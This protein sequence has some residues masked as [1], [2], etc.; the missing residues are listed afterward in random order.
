MVESMKTIVLGL[1]GAHFELIDPWIEEGE[2]PNLKKM[3][4]EGC[5][6]DMKVCLPPVTSP[7]WKCYSTGKNPAELGI[8][9]WE[10]I[11]VKNRRVYYP[12]DR[13][14]NHKEIWDY[15]G[16]EGY[17]VGI[18]GT[19]LTYPARDIN[20]LMVSGGPDAENNS[21]AISGEFKK[22]PGFK[23][24]PNT[25]MKA[26]RIKSAEETVKL[27][28]HNFREALD[29]FE[30]EGLDFMQFTSFNINVL[31]HFLWDH[32]KTL[33]GWKVIDKYLGKLMEKDC[34]T[35]IM[36]DHGSNKIE[37]IFNINIWLEKEGYLKTKKNLFQKLGLSSDVLI[38]LTSKLKIYP[39]LR[40]ILPDKILRKL[41][42][43]GGEVKRE[44]KEDIID[45]EKSKAVAS[46]QGPIYLID[47]EYKKEIKNKL[48]GLKDPKGNEVINKV[49][50]K[51]E[52]YSGKYIKE[53]PDLII[54]QAKGVHI[55]G[56]LGQDKVFGLEVPWVSENKKTGMFMAYGPKIKSKGRIEG[57][58]ILDLA[59]TILRLHGTRKPKG[60]DGKVIEKIKKQGR[61]VKNE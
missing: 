3:K 20:G 17:K 14:F 43:K 41:P 12:Q 16:E 50:E 10:N 60:M 58:S 21:K 59:P 22:R 55:P 34:Q 49:Y 31:H 26:D 45:W 7:N 36:S 37:T 32:E 25:P 48:E 42:S 2:L 29:L 15:L 19:P 23:V 38:K 24:R 61:V 47:K 13:K 57:V 44:G 5:W 30:R 9:W 28:E 53:A 39:F 27:I 46:G 54:D 52:I 4:E 51:E 1:D 33:E 18:I 11:D 6:A 8:F 56:G 40:R 35:F